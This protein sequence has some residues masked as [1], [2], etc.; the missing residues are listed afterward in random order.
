MG[1]AFV[2]DQTAPPSRLVPADPLDA[3][4]PE[5]ASAAVPLALA[6]LPLVP[7]P[8]PLAP[9]SERD[10]AVV[11]VPL[12]PP[13]ARGGP[14]SP[15]AAPPEAPVE[16]PV[17]EP[18]DDPAS[19]PPSAEHP[20]DPARQPTRSARTRGA[21]AVMW[22]TGQSF[23]GRCA[24]RSVLLRPGFPVSIGPLPAPFTSA[25]GAYV[26]TSSTF[27]TTLARTVTSVC[28]WL[29]I[30]A[31]RAPT[32]SLPTGTPSMRKWPAASV[33]ACSG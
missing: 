30:A 28:A 2:G 15:V 21:G 7:P 25:A 12:D 19:D 32:F 13:E 23:G 10:P 33:T 16:A 22:A 24:P 1:A 11:P 27:S 6:P 9:P 20:N 8:A 5:P 3:A 29:S 14:A 17:D 4:D 31:S 18:V 26:S